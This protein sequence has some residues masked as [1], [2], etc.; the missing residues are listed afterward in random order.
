M[1]TMNAELYDALIS[2]GASDEKAREAAKS[3]GEGDVRIRL[4]TW[5]V[6]INLTA[7]LAILFRVFA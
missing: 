6:G 5:M 3:I 2:A 4:L 7:T 1:T